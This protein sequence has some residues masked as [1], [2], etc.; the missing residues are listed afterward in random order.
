MPV[1]DQRPKRRGSAITLLMTLVAAVALVGTTALVLR[2]GPLGAGAGAEDT[3]RVKRGSFSITVPASGELDAL[4]RIEVR[5]KLEARAVITEIVPEGIMAK[6]GD[7]LFRFADEDIRNEIKDEED[8]VNTANSALVTAEAFLDITLSEHQSEM[9]DADLRV[10]LAEL[11]LQAWQEGSVVSRRKTL[12]VEL[13]S[14]QIDRDRAS[15][16]FEDSKRLV[17]D[18]FISRD[19]YKTDEIT[20][21]KAEATLDQAKLA[22]EVY[23]S[24]TYIQEKAQFESDVK[25][26]NAERERIKERQKAQLDSARADLA[27]KKYQHESKVQRLADWN[28]QLEYCTVRAPSDGLVVYYTSLNRDSH[29][30]N[31]NNPPDVGTEMRRNSTVILLPDTSQMIANVKINEAQS[32]L[33]KPGQRATIVSDAVADVIMHGTVL[34]IGVLAESG[35]WRDPNRRDYTVKIQLDDERPGGLKPSM[36]CKTEIEVGG[37]EDALHVPIQAVFRN[38]AGEAYVYVP[39]DSGY[40]QRRVQLGQA[41]ELYW[42]IAGGL[43]IS[44]TVLL[45]EPKPAEVLVRLDAEAPQGAAHATP[46]NRGGSG[47][48]QARTPRH[49]GTTPG[50][51]RP[52]D[53][54]AHRSDEG[55]QARVARYAQRE[56]DAE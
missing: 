49:Q 46:T 31:D 44:E 26:A 53:N 47:P 21:I 12:A 35:G 27:S 36:R 54:R 45:R 3:F 1:K 20:K 7:V 38:P 14:A 13:E 22:I 41:S 40:A 9:E 25:Q 33:I 34:S 39:H 30:G 56:P 43:K 6:A 2:S 23:E 18:G 28:E 51:G 4:N 11:A 8:D 52:D 16:K 10:M 15:E 32:G 55:D 24:Y 19:E 48:V 37:V 42:E 5:N 50:Q 29:R 17:E